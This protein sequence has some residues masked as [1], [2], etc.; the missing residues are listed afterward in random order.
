MGHASENAKP[1]II[2]SISKQPNTNT[3]E[4]TERIEKNL[5]ILQKTLPPDVRLDTK[6][7]RQ[8]DF[9]ETS[10][11]NVQNALNRRWNFC[12]HYTFYFPWQFPH[13]H[14]FTYGHSAFVTGSNFGDKVLW[15][16]YKHH[17]SWGEWP[18]PLV[19]WLMMPLL[20]WKM[21]IN[22]FGKIGKNRK[23]G[24]RLYRGF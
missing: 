23:K 5:E 3:L 7:F 24:N 2:I 4:V 12:N 16:E 17:E 8:A 22:D 19:R 20:M 21:C 11:N 1:A 13:H 6:I 15:F 10:V 9:I 18:L 14:Y